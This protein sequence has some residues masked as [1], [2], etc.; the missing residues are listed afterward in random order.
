MASL[1]YLL[2][3][4]WRADAALLSEDDSLRAALEVYATHE[5]EPE[6]IDGLVGISWA[7]FAAEATAQL[8]RTFH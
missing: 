5:C 3:G 8:A 4:G 1:E 2:P 7:E 6:K